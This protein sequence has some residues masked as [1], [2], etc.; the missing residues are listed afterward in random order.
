[1]SRLSWHKGK[2]FA[3]AGFDAI[4]LSLTKYFANSNLALTSI[5]PTGGDGCIKNFMSGG[6]GGGGYYGGG[7]G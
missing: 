1:L 7:G 3:T 2:R 6:G 4:K 5:F